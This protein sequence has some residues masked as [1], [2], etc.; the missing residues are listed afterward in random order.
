MVGQ[1]TG[2][3]AHDFNNL[4][5]VIL[6]N[7]DLLEEGIAG[8]KKLL[9]LTEVT[10]IAAEKGA[11]LTRRM[12]AFARLQPLAPRS[13]D[14]SRLVED[15]Q[16]LL[17]RS[18]GGHI[19]LALK[20]DV[21]SSTAMVDPGQLESAIF[22]L[23]VNARDA[24]PD[25]GRIIIEVEAVLLDAT[26]SLPDEEVLPG[27]YTMV[28]VT[29][30]GLGMDA[31]TLSRAFEPFFTTKD[32]GKG[33]GLGLSM[34][35][36]FVRQSKGHARIASRPGNGTTVR[37]YLPAEQQI[38]RETPHRFATQ[39]MRRGTERI[40]LV[41]DDDLVRE[42]VV[43]QLRH[44]GYS[45]TSAGCG[46]EALERVRCGEEFDLVFTDIVMPGMNGVDLAKQVRTLR[47][48]LPILY[49]SGYT[50]GALC[51]SGALLLL[52]PYRK[53]DLAEMIRATLDQVP[54]PSQPMDRLLSPK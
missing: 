16:A 5:Q 40:L 17:N 31:D 37:L 12:L 47:P 14:V 33:S 1:L 30:T 4:L 50:D 49:T 2:G 51:D 18:L 45:V 54:H 21:A 46:G 41:E 29:D 11:E 23:C 8:N 24:M 39:P 9:A 6:G 19:E 34:V 3:I 15:M 52:K 20:L 43:E 42:H 22:N 26:H 35:Y 10:R 27:T 38:Q 7:A 48:H 25:G 44:L 36:G 13:T 32:V 53:K 28:S